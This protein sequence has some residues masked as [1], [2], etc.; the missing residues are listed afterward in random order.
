MSTMTWKP[1]ASTTSMTRS[2]TASA[3]DGGTCPLG[4]RDPARSSK[5]TMAAGRGEQT[6]PAGAA[7]VLLPQPSSTRQLGCAPP[8]RPECDVAPGPPESSTDGQQ[9]DGRR[10]GRRNRTESAGWT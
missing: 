4:K 1:Q 7:V 5:A 3:P 2:M 6:T 9:E 8:G 10:E